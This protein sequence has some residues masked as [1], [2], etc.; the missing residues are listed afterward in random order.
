M[1]YKK[2]FFCQKNACVAVK[3]MIYSIPINDYY[4][5]YKER[6]AFSIIIL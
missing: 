1:M 3:N 2:Y 5:N 4:G 6:Y